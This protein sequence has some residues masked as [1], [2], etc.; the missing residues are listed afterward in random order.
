MERLE[1][2]TVLRLADHMLFPTGSA[3]LTG[4]GSRVMDR[5]GSVL[6]RYPDHEIR[7][8]GHTDNRPIRAEAKDRFAS[9]WELSTARATTV[10]RKMINEFK[11]SPTRLVAVG[12]GEFMPVTSNATTE[13]RSRN[14]RVEIHIAMPQP[15]KEMLP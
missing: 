6:S 15:L 11:L 3:Q 14:R 7:V 5:L 13:G 12:R 1:Q 9:N 8:E 2:M 4:D 10:V